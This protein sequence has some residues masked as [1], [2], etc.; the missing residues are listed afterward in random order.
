[1]TANARKKMLN[2]LLG[3]IFSFQAQIL[4]NRDGFSKFSLFHFMVGQ[5]ENFSFNKTRFQILI[6]EFKVKNFSL[7]NRNFMLRE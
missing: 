5:N 4:K 1:M 6:Y 7:K 2:E 3:I